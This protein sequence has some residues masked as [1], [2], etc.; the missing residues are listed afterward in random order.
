MKLLVLGGTAF[1][2]ARFVEAALDR[3]HE[4]CLFTR[5][6]TKSGRFGDTVQHVVGDRDPIVDSGLRNLE[7]VLAEQRFDA[8]VDISGYLPRHVRATAEMC[9]PR[10]D[11]YLFI[12]SVSVYQEPLADRADEDSALIRLADP[13]VEEITAAT[14]GGLKVICEEVVRE[15]C[16]DKALIVRPGIIGGRED[17]TDRLTYWPWVARA[18]L[19]GGFIAPGEGNDLTSVIDARDLAAWMVALVEQGAAGVRAASGHDTFNTSGVP[20]PMSAVIEAAVAAAMQAS[21]A[22]SAD[23]PKAH[24]L[25]LETLAA[26]GVQPWSDLPLWMPEE[27][28]RGGILTASSD[29][30]VA[31]GLERRPIAETILDALAGFD[32]S[33]PP[34]AGLPLERMRAVLAAVSAPD[35]DRN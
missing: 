22:P 1:L 11:T 13:T 25:K 18:A 5:G 6:R 21:G 2:G 34:K 14:Y 32:D 28:G 27:V 7:A 26:H 24:W 9:A 15:V 17:F 30:A 20:T 33:A 35:D 19:G 8:V 12:S 31:M 10:T 3:G 16:G 29:R 23:A 4:L